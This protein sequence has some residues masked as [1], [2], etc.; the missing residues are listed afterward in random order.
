M[1]A[2]GVIDSRVVTV[3][4]I[5]VAVTVE[6]DPDSHPMDAECYTTEDLAAWLCDEWTYV[7]VIMADAES[8]IRVTLG[9]VEWGFLAGRCIGMD[10]IIG[11][12]VPDLI[13]ELV[14]EIIGQI[15]RLSAV[16]GRY[17][18]SN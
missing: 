15:L 18:N 9:G 17:G 5:A 2:W 10:E 6:G 16:I 7:T 11:T 1:S 13:T 12:H 14:A 4:G 8:G 3:H